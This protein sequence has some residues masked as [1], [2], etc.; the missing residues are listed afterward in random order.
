[1]KGD[2]RKPPKRR[3]PKI[4]WSWLTRPGTYRL[5]VQLLRLVSEIAKAIDKF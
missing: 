4:Q 5:A 1:M 2:V 3:A